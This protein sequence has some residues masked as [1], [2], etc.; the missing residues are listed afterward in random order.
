[1]IGKVCGQ[2]QE[3]IHKFPP[4]SRPRTFAVAG[5]SPPSAERIALAEEGLRG[6]QQSGPSSLSSILS[7]SGRSIPW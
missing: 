3:M 6:H 4:G 5:R 7:Q 1:M 2:C